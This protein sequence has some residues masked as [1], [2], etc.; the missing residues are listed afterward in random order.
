MYSPAHGMW[1]LCTIESAGVQTLAISL[2][3]GENFVAGFM[4]KSLAPPRPASVEF[5][6]GSIVIPAGESRTTTESVP[7]GLDLCG[8]SEIFSHPF[9]VHQLGRRR[10]SFVLPAVGGLQT[11]REG[12]CIIVVFTWGTSATVS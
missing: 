3:H 4:R 7:I 2:G 10:D 5:V 1:R 8:L 9:S 6:K 12:V 11:E